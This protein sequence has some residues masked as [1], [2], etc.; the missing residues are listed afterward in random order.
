MPKVKKNLGGA[1]FFEKGGGTLTQKG[2]K[3]FLDIQEASLKRRTISVQLLDIKLQTDKYIVRLT[4]M[5]VIAL[6][7]FKKYKLQQF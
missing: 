3:P 6:N 5:V 4:F 2:Y 7:I 1:S